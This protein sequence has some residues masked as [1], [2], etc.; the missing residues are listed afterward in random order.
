MLNPPPNDCMPHGL[1]EVGAAEVPGAVVIAALV[2]AELVP[3][4]NK[5]DGVELA[6][7]VGDATCGPKPIA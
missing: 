4:L 7:V 5:K 1:E 2:P 3:V 6:P